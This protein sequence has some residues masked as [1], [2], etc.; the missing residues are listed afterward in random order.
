MCVRTTDAERTDS[1]TARRTVSSPLSQF[2]IDVKRTIR[3]INLRIRFNEV[4]ARRKPCVTESA[5]GFDQAGDPGGCVKV[6]DIRLH[7]T[8]SAELLS[9]RFSAYRCGLYV[10][11]AI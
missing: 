2:R 11:N 4:Q 9:L 1:S 5:N 3:K 7:G 10:K 8:N 6:A